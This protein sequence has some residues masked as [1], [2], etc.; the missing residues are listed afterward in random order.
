MLSLLN[1]YTWSDLADRDV[2]KL[3]YVLPIS[4]LEQHG[5]HLPLGCDDF[6]LQAALSR[7]V[8]DER[9]AEDML[10]LPTVHFGN[11]HEHLGFPGVVSLSC[12]TIVALVR[13]VL[14]SMQCTGV[15]RLVLLNSHGGNTALLNAYAQEWEH[16]FDIRV[17]NISLWST[18]FFKGG[19]PLIETPMAHEVHGGEIETSILMAAAP[20]LVQTGHIA[21]END[22]IL[23][24]SELHQ[25]W[26]SASLSPQNGVI[27]AASRA[28]AQTGER[29]LAYTADRI[30]AGLNEISQL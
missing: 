1:R 16:E 5:R 20:E 23:T 18:S 21:P 3:W 27:G 26:S 30:V 13:D 9:V 7:V 17:F 15:T 8:G 6:I 11:S 29:L 19:Q 14:H 25:G 22:V 28:T 12:G 10:V 2:S 24:L 4:A